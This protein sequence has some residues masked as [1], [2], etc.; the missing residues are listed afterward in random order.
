VASIYDALLMGDAEGPS[1]V[2]AGKHGLFAARMAELRRPLPSRRKQGL[3]LQDIAAMAGLQRE[4][5]ATLMEHHGYLELVPYGGTQ[6]RRLVTKRA[7]DA[8]LG[9][10]VDG[11]RCRIARLEGMSRAA[12]FPIFYPKKVPDILWSLD[13]AG[14]TAR[15]AAIEGK[16]D[17]MR[18]L[19][20]HHGYLPDAEL[21]K[22]SGYS[23]RG[24]RKARKSS[25]QH[26]APA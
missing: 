24:V 25:G 20:N 7:F 14:M 22:L 5:L 2:D 10:N 6:R 11:S 18:W 15:A 8:G 21:A 23:E 4:T 9:H 12:V 26:R 13:H 17:R 3:T 1:S 16:R 19:L